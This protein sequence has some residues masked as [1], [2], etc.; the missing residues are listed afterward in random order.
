MII[1]KLNAQQA[2]ELLQ[3]LD[4]GLS[5]EKDMFTY[6]ATSDTMKEIW[7]LMANH[8]AYMEDHYGAYME[9]LEDFES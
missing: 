3:L 6:T 2:T 7:D 9:D 5:G 8:P 1:L 4:A